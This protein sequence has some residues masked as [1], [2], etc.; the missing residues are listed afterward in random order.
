MT[1][2]AKTQRDILLV[3]DT[4]VLNVVK[5]AL[6]STNPDKGVMFNLFNIYNANVE[7]EKVPPQRPNE[8]TL[9]DKVRMFLAHP[10]TINDYNSRLDAIEALAIRVVAEEYSGNLKEMARY[11]GV[12]YQKLKSRIEKYNIQVKSRRYR[13]R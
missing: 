7:Q 10:S 1:V 6:S 8:E 9:K 4:K 5:T 12:T 13:G 11:L 3:Q 2:P